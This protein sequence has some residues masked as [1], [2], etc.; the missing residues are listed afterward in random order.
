MKRFDSIQMCSSILGS[1]F[2]SG[3]WI[4]LL[5]EHPTKSNSKQCKNTKKIKLFVDFCWV[6][7]GLLD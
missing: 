3:F 2:F 1:Q 6:F 7:V 5:I 4:G